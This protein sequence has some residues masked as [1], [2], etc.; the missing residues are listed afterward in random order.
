MAR[1]PPLRALRWGPPL[2]HI[3]DERPQRA[4]TALETLGPVAVSV[5][6]AL[7]AFFAGL[8]YLPARERP[9]VTI[10]GAISLK[11]EWD[12]FLHLGA[13]ALAVALLPVLCLLRGKAN[14]WPA[15][16][17]RGATQVA[18][19]ALGA[20]A[21]VEAFLLG[22]RPLLTGGE[23]EARYGLIFAAAVALLIAGSVLG[24]GASGPARALVPD[25]E[26]SPRFNL[27]D[28]LVPV[29]LVAVVFAPA[30]GQL[31]GFT[32]Q[33]DAMLHWDYFAMGP[34]TAYASGLALGTDVQTFYGLG[35]PM[36]FTA[37]SPVVELSYQHMIAANVI[38]TCLY[39][40]G[41]YA[42][43]RLLLRNRAW[44][45]TGATLVL[46]FHVFARS[47]AAFAPYWGFPS[48]GILRWSFDVWAFIALLL[49]Q[50]SGR[51]RWAIVA[52]GVLGLAVVFETD[53]GLLL[54]LATAFFWAAEL[55]VSPDR[56]QLMRPLLASA[57][58]AGGVLLAGLVVASR[59]TL[60]QAAFWRGWLYNLGETSSGFSLE[61]I[62][63]GVG[64]Q[65]VIAFVVVSATYLVV[66]GRTLVLTTRR[67]A[68]EF[69]VVAGALAIYGYVVLLYFV[70]RSTPYNFVRATIPFA[71][72]TAML[73]A[74]A[75]RT[76]LATRPAT[77]RLAGLASV[78]V[79]VALLAAN[80]VFRAYERQVAL[81]GHIA[82]SAV[83][84]A[85]VCLL[86]APEDICGLTEAFRPAATNIAAIAQRLRELAPGEKT[87]AVLDQIG[88]MFHLAAG[89]RPWG[90]YN[91]YFLV[92]ARQA[93]LEE[94]VDD[95]RSDPPA[96]VVFRAGDQP[97]FADILIALRGATSERFVL[98]SQIGGFEIWRPR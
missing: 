80:P 72:V 77:E 76:F 33:L 53:T 28:G 10:A 45:A 1:L 40:V 9:A 34:A 70:G 31:A 64:R 32:Y 85:G 61:P 23:V 50:R 62:T 82:G 26:A 38:V 24:R 79:A 84:D 12:S 25:T 56:R 69:D 11:P 3:E 90:R 95:F 83:P 94:V 78:A 98:D 19:A 51:P 66:V 58:T 46:V 89:T 36:L 86:D 57:A 14:G 73:G 6:I 87:V 21:A 7:N 2:I 44:A 96:V 93:Q 68:S 35:W 22:R 29:A 16:A 71:L 67:R 17:L 20:A 88:P 5:A 13:G 59:G 81:P 18:V 49:F 4:L 43:L 48:L 97:L 54:A 30:W 52:G 55:Y 39:L 42:F 91:P 37:L 74:K 65:V 41:V 47:A 8:L 27:F 63:T 92:L 75:G 15:P 60:F